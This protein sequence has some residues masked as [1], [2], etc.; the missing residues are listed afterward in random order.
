MR[1]RGAGEEGT[2]AQAREGQSPDRGQ[3]GKQDPCVPSKCGSKEGEPF[4]SLWLAH[5]GQ[6][7]LT[8]VVGR[9]VGLRVS[10]HG[11]G[12]DPVRDFGFQLAPEAAA[13]G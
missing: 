7:D 1:K 5:P 4:Q 3:G 11:A 9:C 13:T 6:R 8:G 2:G 10:R 12:S